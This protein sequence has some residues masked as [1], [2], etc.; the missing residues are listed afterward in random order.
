[1]ISVWKKYLNE[2]CLC[3]PSS[4]DHLHLWLL[5]KSQVFI[6][7]ANWPCSSIINYH[8]TGQQLQFNKKKIMVKI[9]ELCSEKRIC[10]VY[11]HT[12]GHSVRQISKQI[13]VPSSTI[14]YIIR[15]F[16]ND[17]LIIENRRRSGRPRKTRTRSITVSNIKKTLRE[18]HLC[19][20]RESD[21]KVA[22]LRVI[23]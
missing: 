17:G 21:E 1:M 10:I 12:L 15:K 4:V 6:L 9:S 20:H 8:E 22:F 19:S 23:R 11:L 13:N 7:C 18:S 16:K 5:C 3:G 2:F 14:Q